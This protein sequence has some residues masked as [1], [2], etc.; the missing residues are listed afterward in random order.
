LCAMVVVS[1]ACVTGHPAAHTAS[2]SQSP[3]ATAPPSP[4][5]TPTPVPQQAELSLPVPRQEVASATAGLNL[6]VVGGFDAGRRDSSSVSVYSGGAWERGTDLPIAVDHAS[7]ASYQG[8]AYVAGGNS[9]GQSLGSVYRLEEGGWTRLRPMGHP[10]AAFGLVAVGNRFYAIGGFGGGVE[11]A[12]V[13][14]YDPVADRWSDVATLPLPR[15]HVAGFAWQGQA[16]V[17]GGRSPTTARVDC[18][19]PVSSAWTRL[20]DLPIPTS[21]AGSTT[22]SGQVIVAGGENAAESTLVGHVFRFAGGSAW[23][24]EPM[25]VPR[26]GIQLAVWGGRAWACG[27]ATAAGYQAAADCTSIG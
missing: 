14:A 21:G 3:S 26:H 17:A 13:E 25:L 4:S 19:D 7:A 20:A 15:D 23:A 5:P 6:I 11:V 27:G 18:Y 1:C 10:R 22:L 24:D 16:C 9:N 8:T 2:P 12:A